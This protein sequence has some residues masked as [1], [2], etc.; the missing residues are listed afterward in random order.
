MRENPHC[1]KMAAQGVTACGALSVFSFFFCFF[2]GLLYLN[3]AVL[4]FF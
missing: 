2:G 1:V 3:V 4:T